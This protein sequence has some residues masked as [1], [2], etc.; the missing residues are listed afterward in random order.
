[1]ELA[2]KRSCRTMSN[3]DRELPQHLRFV[4]NRV[5]KHTQMGNPIALPPAAV[6]VALAGTFKQRSVIG[7]AQSAWR[8]TS[9]LR[10]RAIRSAR[11]SVRR[12]LPPLTPGSRLKCPV[13]TT[14]LVPGLP[15]EGQ[16]GSENINSSP[17]RS[18]CYRRQTYSS[19]THDSSSN[20]TPFRKWG[21]LQL[22]MGLKA[23]LRPQSLLSFGTC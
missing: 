21:H 2:R 3:V 20:K 6:V 11:V 10:G 23:R 22:A 17:S 8:L 14:R 4:A 15:C 13:V 19:R 18:R 16:G 5:C 7:A 1:M 12:T 9:K